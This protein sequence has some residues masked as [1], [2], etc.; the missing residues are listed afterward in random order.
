MLEKIIDEI[1]RI[2]LLFSSKIRSGIK[3]YFFIVNFVNI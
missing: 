3:E 2:I 1:K